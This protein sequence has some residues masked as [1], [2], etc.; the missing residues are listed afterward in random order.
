MAQRFTRS[1][2]KPKASAH[3]LA[4]RFRRHELQRPARTILCLHSI[5]N[6]RK[7]GCREIGFI[8]P[9]DTVRAARDPEA[10]LLEF[11]SSRYAAAADE[12]R[13]EREQLQCTLGV[14]GRVRLL[15]PGEPGSV[16]GTGG[17]REIHRE[18]VH[19]D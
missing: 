15:A 10:M 9:Y 17:G 2:N 16:A 14:P 6:N 13:W 5:A 7:T 19:R 8:L 4:I 18:F 1:H 12:A 11:L 3:A